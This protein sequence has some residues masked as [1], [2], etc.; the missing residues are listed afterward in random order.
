MIVSTSDCPV[1]VSNRTDELLEDSNCNVRAH[2]STECTAGT[3]ILTC[4]G[5]GSIALKVYLFSEGEQ[6]AR[7]GDCAEP[8]SLTTY[9]VNNY[10][11]HEAFP[12]AV[13]R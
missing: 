8:A 2:F 10:F 13:K 12:S 1:I 3:F 11:C 7:T 6:L 9:F 5:S 4:Y